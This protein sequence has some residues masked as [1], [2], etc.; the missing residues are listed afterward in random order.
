MP[1]SIFISKFKFYACAGVVL[2]VSSGLGVS[3]AARAA[4]PAPAPAPKSDKTL[5]PEEE[6]FMNTPFTNYGE[7]N[8]EKEEDEDLKFFQNGRFAGVSAG[9]GFQ[10]VTG[11]RG[12]LWQGGFPLVDLKVHYWFDFNFAIA[13]GVSFVNAYYQS[14]TG[15]GHV[16]V[17]MT[18]VGLDLKYYFDTKNM[19]AAISFANPYLIGG[20]GAF[21]KNETYQTSQNVDSETSVGFDLGAGLEFTL[22]PR[23]SYFELEGKV[24]L[25]NFNDTYTQKYQGS[26]S[27]PQLQDLTGAF[28]TLTASLLFT[29]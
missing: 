26:N 15:L 9:L 21:S 10:S 6:D 16:D 11:N 27:S 19:G 12:L 7:F 18:R 20:L 3:T 13:L 4:D 14:P 17:S 29:W 2:A 8:Q 25:V 22:S 23:K 5:Q 28:L 24:N 1:E